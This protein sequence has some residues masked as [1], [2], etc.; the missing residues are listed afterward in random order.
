MEKEGMSWLGKR[1]DELAWK[2]RGRVGLEKERKEFL[3][4]REN[5]Y[6]CS[7]IVMRGSYPHTSKKREA[8]Q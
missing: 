5:A 7:I 6:I 8:K 1:G 2:R 4:Y 3:F